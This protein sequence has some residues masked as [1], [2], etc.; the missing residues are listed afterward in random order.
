MQQLPFLEQLLK[1]N[2]CGKGSSWLLLRDNLLYA[3]SEYTNKIET[4]TIDDRIQGKLTL[5][6]TISAIGSIP[7]SLDI[8]STGKWLAVAK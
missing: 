7:C 4:Y 6:N 3:V 2:K 1:E 5:K 8:D